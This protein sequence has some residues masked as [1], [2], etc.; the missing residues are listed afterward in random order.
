VYG[1]LDYSFNKYHRHIQ[2]H[3]E[4]YPDRKSK[5]LGHKNGGQCNPN[6][7]Q[8]KFM[9]LQHQ[10]LP[11]GCYR[12]IQK[13]NLCS[14]QKGKEACLNEKISIMEVCPDHILEGLRE[15]RKWIL[16]A[17][18]IDNETYK[19]AMKVSDYNKGKSVGDLTI[20]DWSYG[21]P[22]N[23][24]SDSTWEDDRYDPTKFPHPHRYD[25]VNFK[26]QEYTDVFGGT[27]GDGERAE[28]D[29]YAYKL[30]SGTSNAEIDQKK[31]QRK[32]DL[33]TMVGEVDALNKKE[34]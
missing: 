16:R 29:F 33:K 4:W 10:T 15:K 11:R 20:R 22:K 21:S 3:D 27:K 5:T 32:D 17:Q 9:V 25:N 6:M 7:K 1:N 31:K 24:R 30:S 18:A 8:S 26:E 19:R 2:A 28:L 23:M 13:Y 12:E 14:N 34:E